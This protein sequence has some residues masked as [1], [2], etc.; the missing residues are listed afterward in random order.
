MEYDMEGFDCDYDEDGEFDHEYD[1]DS[2]IEGAEESSEFDSET[3]SEEEI[4]FE[5][6]G[7]EGFQPVDSIEDLV[8]VNEDIP[9]AP[10]AINENGV[11]EYLDIPQVPVDEAY[12]N[13]YGE[14][15]DELEKDEVEEIPDENDE[16]LVPEIPEANVEIDE[17]GDFLTEDEIMED[18]QK[19]WEQKEW[20][21]NI[22]EMAREEIGLED[23]ETFKDWQEELEE[24]VRHE[25]AHR[26][27]HKN[28]NWAENI[29]MK[30]KERE[31]FEEIPE[32]D[33]VLNKED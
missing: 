23:D 8:G 26:E 14:Q 2:E 10:E 18:Q 25:I 9:T 21:R 7:E 19:E 6:Y 11:P 27:E 20:D 4:D 24:D 31:V 33:I 29:D 28:P 1:E 17:R 5:I 32:E 22:D 30:E 13:R 12:L 3:V 16:I 15:W